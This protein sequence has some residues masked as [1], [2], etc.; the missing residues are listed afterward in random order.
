M[1]ADFEPPADRSQRTQKM[2]ARLIALLHDL[3]APL[4]RAPSSTEI[5][6]EADQHSRR[7]FYL[8]FR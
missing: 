3:V 2:Y 5:A 8:P 1:A 6:F 7:A 4:S